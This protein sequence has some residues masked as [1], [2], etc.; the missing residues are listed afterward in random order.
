MSRFLVIKVDDTKDPQQRNPTVKPF[1]GM[2]AFNLDEV[3]H[4]M[5][6]RC[7]LA[8]RV[9]VVPKS[10]KP[11]VRVFTDALPEVVLRQITP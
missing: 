1:V 8:T 10:G 7:G 3:A 6:D 9:I 11:P 5:A 4:V 2:Q